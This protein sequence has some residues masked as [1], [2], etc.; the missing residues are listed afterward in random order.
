MRW[1]LLIEEFV[2]NNSNSYMFKSLGQLRYYSCLA[3]V[4][5]VIGNSS[6]GLLEAPSFKVGTINIGDRQKGRVKA[7][8][9]ID[10]YANSEQIKL[11][12]NYLYSKEFI[13]ILRTVQNPYGKGGASKKIVKELVNFPLDGIIKK[14]F[15]DI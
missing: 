11:A 9:V 15:Q 1:Q 6:S 2:S 14:S 4:D 3:N 13:K 5:G 10:C 12:I 7:K 8:S